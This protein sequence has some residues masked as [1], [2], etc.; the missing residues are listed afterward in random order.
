MPGVSLMCPSGMDIFC[1][2]YRAVYDSWTNKPST[3][4]SAKYNTWVLSKIADGTWAKRDIIYNFAVHT[5]ADGEA[6]VNWKNPGTCN[7]TL[8]NAPAFVAYEGFTSDGSTSYIRSNYIPSVNGATWLQDNASAGIYIRTDTAAG[9]LR[10]M[11]VNAT[12][13]THILTRYTGDVANIR[14]NSIASTSIA[15]ADAK[16]MYITNRVLSTHQDLY[17]NKVRIMNG[18]R[19]SSGISDGEIY[20]LCLNNVPAP[21]EFSDRQA[22]M[23]VMGGGLTTDNIDDETDNFEAYMDSQGTGIIP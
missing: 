17:R 12:H 14:L 20:I 2:E 3:A 6:L 16:G 23:V 7:A 9:A 1:A 13:D 8:V 22:S 5:N 21:S 18:V 10:E 11:G 19:D 15:N 4:D